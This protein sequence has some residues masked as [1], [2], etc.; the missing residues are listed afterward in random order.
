MN[1]EKFFEKHKEISE[2]DFRLELLWS[3]KIIHGKLHRIRKNL[4]RIVWITMIAVIVCSLA[5]LY[6]ISK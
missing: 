4:T 1:K 6:H 3:Q 2:G 5:L